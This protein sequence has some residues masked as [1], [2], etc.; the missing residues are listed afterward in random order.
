MLVCNDLG[1]DLIL[2]ADFISKTEIILDVH[3]KEY[4]FRFDRTRKYNFDCE[5]EEQESTGSST[6]HIVPVSY[7]HLDVY[8]RQVCKHRDANKDTSL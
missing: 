7:T 2:G 6:A 4:Y 8:K 1:P 3:E 5:T